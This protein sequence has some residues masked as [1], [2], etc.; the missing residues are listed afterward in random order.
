MFFP[1][2][3]VKDTIKTLF[4]DAKLYKS[5][6]DALPAALSAFEQNVRYGKELKLGILYQKKGQ[7][8][9]DE[10]YG[11]NAGSPEFQEFLEWIGTRIELKNWTKFRGGL[12]ITSTLMFFRS[13]ISAANSTG[14]YSLYTTF[15]DVE[16]MFHVAMYIPYSVD[17]SQQVR[18]YCSARCFT[19]S[20]VLIP[21]CRWNVSAT[22][23]T[24]L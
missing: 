17:D 12:N 9:E 23:A 10:I 24:I 2:A 1:P 19:W 18:T 15:Q 6:A 3:P 14:V 4:P 22:Q 8:T 16:I 20:A 21:L 11:N 5:D 13:L 7:L